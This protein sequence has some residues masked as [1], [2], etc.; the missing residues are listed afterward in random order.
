MKSVP[1]RAPVTSSTVIHPSARPASVAMVAMVIAAA[2]P[3]SS[4]RGG[5]EEQSAPAPDERETEGCDGYE[6]RTEDHG[7]DNEDLGVHDNG[8]TGEHRGQGH[9]G[10]VR[11]VEFG[12]LVG[13]LGDVRPHDGIGAAA[14]RV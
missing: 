5:E 8:D 1:G 13:A 9:E 14:G 4:V 11:P 6:L 10:Q 7:A 12:L 3:R 2:K